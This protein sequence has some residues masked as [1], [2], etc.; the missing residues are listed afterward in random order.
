M[1]PPYS[2]SRKRV[3][4]PHPPFRTLAIGNNLQFFF[5]ILNVET[6]VQ[7]RKNI[8]GYTAILRYYLEYLNMSL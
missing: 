1:A 2:G 4:I 6:N 3:L 8:N 5:I 7:F